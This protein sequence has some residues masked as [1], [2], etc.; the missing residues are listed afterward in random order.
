VS[1]G[2]VPKA[3]A[4]L[5]ALKKTYP[6]SPTVFDLEAL[7][8]LAEKRPDAARAAYV[9]AFELKSDDIEALGGL[10]RLDIASG[11]RQ[12]ATARLES[13]LVKA[14]NNPALLILAARTQA[15]IGE[16]AKSEALLQRALEV[17]PSSLQT[18]SL[19][20]QLYAQQRRTGEA[21]AKFQEV[22]RRDPKSI[23]ASTMLAMLWEGEG[24]KAEAVKEY[25]HALSIDPRAG[26]AA[27]NLAYIYVSADKQ[28][29]EAL[30]L[31]QTAV[32]AMPDEPVVNDTLGWIYV[33]KNQAAL[34]VHHL[35]SSVQKTPDDPVFNYHLGMAYVQTGEFDKAKRA[36]TKALSIR[37]DFEGAA[38]A[39]KALA[40][41]G[42]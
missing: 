23:G 12:D 26:V 30:Q 4:V 19:L 7:T 36:L 16:P 22:L 6:T 38:A 24:N 42:G 15:T 8:N 13:A 29:D 1:Q 41:V 14:P 5:A 33:R 35:E 9:R 27:N 21:K 3:R 17:D 25:Q 40:T 18:Y 2:D 39:R 10:A 37:P 31:A 20:G 28:L 11:R 34:G 32:R